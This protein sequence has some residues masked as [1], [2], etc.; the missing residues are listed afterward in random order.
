MNEKFK[1]GNFLKFCTAGQSYALALFNFKSAR[2]SNTYKAYT[3]SSIG[4]YNSSIYCF[5]KIYIEFAL[6]IFQLI[7]PYNQKFTK[8]YG[9]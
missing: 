3:I 6:T 2:F 9:G 1:S 7:P 5:R 8:T 4:V